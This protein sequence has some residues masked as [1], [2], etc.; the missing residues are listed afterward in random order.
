MH[1]YIHT[2]LG[3]C[4][5]ALNRYVCGGE[6]VGLC[7]FLHPCGSQEVDADLQ[8]Q[9]L[10]PS[11]TEPSYNTVCAFSSQDI[12]HSVCMRQA[13]PISSVAS[14]CPLPPGFPVPF[15]TWTSV[16]FSG[17]ISIIFRVF[18]QAVTFSVECWW[19]HYPIL[20]FLTDLEVVIPSNSGTIS[21]FVSSV[22]DLVDTKWGAV[23]M[24]SQFGPI[25]P[26]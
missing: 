10:V 25:L 16:C 18:L 12:I 9:C 22:F 3:R 15:L 1:T 6:L 17:I 4:A 20:K 21:P 8:V 7:S 14:G 2:Q 23:R 11:P 5:Y 26:D 24:I 19:T 13:S